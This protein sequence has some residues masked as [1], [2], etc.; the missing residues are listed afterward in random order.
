MPRGP[1]KKKNIFVLLCV[2]Q[3]SAPAFFYICGPG[4]LT[5]CTSRLNREWS[6]SG[7]IWE[8]LGKRRIKYNF[9]WKHGLETSN[10]LGL[11][12]Q[13]PM[14]WFLQVRVARLARNG[15]RALP[16]TSRHESRRQ[17]S[18]KRPK[19]FQR[20]SKHFRSKKKHLPGTSEVKGTA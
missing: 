5:L 4:T 20:E 2:S 3:F 6:W 9:S 10:F 1:L 18:D 15:L 8:H 19:H 16:V 7:Q 13:L 14:L 11:R 12:S 17:H